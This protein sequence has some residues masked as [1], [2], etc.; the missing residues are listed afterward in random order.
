MTLRLQGRGDA[1]PHTKQSQT[2]VLCSGGASRRG[3]TVGAT[4]ARFIELQPLLGTAVEPVAAR[5]SQTCGLWCTLRG[6]AK[7]GAGIRCSCATPASQFVPQA[8]QESRLC[9]TTAAHWPIQCRL[10]QQRKGLFQVSTIVLGTE[11]T[12]RLDRHAKA[13]DYLISTWHGCESALR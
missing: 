3:E 4:P 2:V 13:A 9:T 6:D 11:Q 5:F 12:N 1:P 10:S 8:V 7:I